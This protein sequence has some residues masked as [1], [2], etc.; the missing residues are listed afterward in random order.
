MVEI[1]NFNLPVR[2]ENMM[3]KIKIVALIGKAG[4][5]K[6]FWLR[7]ICENWEEVH[8]IISCTTRPARF[9]EI[10]DV[11]Y[12]FLSEEQFLSQQFVEDCMFRGWRYGTRLEDLD[13]DR[14]NVGVF[15]LSGIGQLLKNP[16]IELIVINIIADDKI[17]LIRQLERDSS[18]IDEIFRR[19]YADE[20]DF[21]IQR[22][23]SIKDKLKYY[24]PV[25][26]NSNYNDDDNEFI[27]EDLDEII[28]KAIND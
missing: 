24:W 15:N 16:F 8:E 3:K 20:K 17:R 22:L 5:G 18:D 9:G 21:A 23:D 6:D 25:I 19:Y 10:N 2:K 13:P 4:A 1:L 7:Y 14:V 28:Q 27:R 26:N 12:H 11:N